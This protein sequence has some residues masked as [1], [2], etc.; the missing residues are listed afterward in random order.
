MSELSDGAIDTVLEWAPKIPCKESLIE[1]NTIG[2]AISDM[3]EDGT[4]CSHRGARYN[5]LIVSMWDDPGED[6]ANLGYP[7]ESFDAMAPYHDGGVYVNFLSVEGADRVRAAYDPDVYS[8]LVDVKRRYDP[9][10]LFQ[11]N[12][13]IPP[14]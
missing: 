8:R 7:Q 14:G 13:N 12:Q 1:I 11:R 9:D 5:H 2:G 6:D 10:N 3:G 4:A